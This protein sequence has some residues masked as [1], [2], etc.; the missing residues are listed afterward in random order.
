MKIYTIVYETEDGREEDVLVPG[1]TEEEADAFFFDT[2]VSDKRMPPIYMR[3]ICP[4]PFV[5]TD[6]QE[7]EYLPYKER[8]LT[9]DEFVFEIKREGLL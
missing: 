3:S 2:I 8:G 1:E 6:K 5:L 7:E 4:T 9:Y